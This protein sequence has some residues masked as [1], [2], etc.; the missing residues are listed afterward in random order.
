MIQE[1]HKVPAPAPEFPPLWDAALR[2]QLLPGENA[3]AV[4]EVDLDHRL[5]FVPGILVLT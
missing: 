3:W 5:H 4:L 1:L 2:Q